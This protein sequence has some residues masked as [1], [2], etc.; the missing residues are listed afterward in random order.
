[1]NLI[2]RGRLPKISNKLVH[3]LARHRLQQA[4]RR[5][6]A[7]NY[8]PLLY[9]KTFA[10]VTLVRVLGPGQKPMDSDNLAILLAGLR[11][12][13]KPAYIVDDSPRWASFVYENDGSR[14][15]QGPAIEVRIRYGGKP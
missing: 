5:V 2:Y 1:M 7:A 11:D 6:L 9:A 3:P 15:D 14:R 4:A 13:L 8:P 12:A 10:Q